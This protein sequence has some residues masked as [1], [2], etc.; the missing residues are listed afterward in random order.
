MYAQIALRPAEV[1]NAARAEKPAE[2]GDNLPDAPSTVANDQG[3]EAGAASVSGT[4]LDISGA[5]ISGAEVTLIETRKSQERSTTTGTDGSFSFSALA[6]GSYTIVVKA[7]AFQQS[8]SPQFT[9]TGHQV[10]QVASI[11]LSIAAPSTSVVV[12]P[13]EVIAAQQVKAEEKQRVIGVIPNFYTSYIWDAAPLNTKQKFS[14][15]LRDTFDPVSVIGVSLGAGIEQARN[16][17]PGYGQGAAGY[18]K[19]WGALFANGRT[20]DILSRAVFPSLLHQDPRYFYQGSGST[21][22]RINHAVGNAFVARSDSGHLMPNYSY[23]LGDLCSGAIS[24]LYYPASSRGA[25][26]VFTN[27][28]LGLAGRAGQGLIREFVLKHITKNVPG[29]GKPVSNGQNP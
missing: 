22:S 13:N 17:F 26:L 1:Q 15:A 7:S 29:Q 23:F 8:A 12:R 6:P 24:N 21:W 4:V 20:S 3:E 28:A 2:T 11:V 16:T 10:Y 18:G 19:R 9:L 25:G 5:A 27:A 14:L